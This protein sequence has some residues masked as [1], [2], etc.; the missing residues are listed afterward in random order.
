[1][2]SSGELNNIPPRHEDDVVVANAVNMVGCLDDKT[3][4]VNRQP[5]KL[6]WMEEKGRTY[7]LLLHTKEKIGKMKSSTRKRGKKMTVRW[8]CMFDLKL[9]IF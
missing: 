1:M 2:Q 5:T 7:L 4:A 9:A 6:T 3:T 8:I